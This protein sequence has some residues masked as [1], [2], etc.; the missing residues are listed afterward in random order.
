MNIIIQSILLSFGICYISIPVIISIASIKKLY[1]E[2]TARK[3]HCQP[4]PALGGVALFAAVLI[5]STFFIN[6][7]I[8]SELQYLIPSSIILFFIGLKDD[9]L[10]ISPFKK[11]AGQILSAFILIYKGNFLIDLILS[12]IDKSS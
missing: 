10:V 11:F 7:S 9:L 1:D 12:S 2:P 5:S 3:I 6:F 8:S 4:V